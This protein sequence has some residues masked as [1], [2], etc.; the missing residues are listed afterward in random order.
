MPFELLFTEQAGSDLDSLKADAGLEQ[1]H[2]AV[3]KALAFLEQNPR[4]PSLN[5]HK[6]SSFIGRNGEE[7]FEA[8]AQNRT[9]AA[10]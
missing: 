9:P 1:Q 5:T 10:L 2:K 6:Y 3:C 7:V 8:Y 4:H